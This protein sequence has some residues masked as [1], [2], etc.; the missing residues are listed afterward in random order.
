MQRWRDWRSKADV[1]NARLLGHAKKKYPVVDPMPG[2]WIDE[3]N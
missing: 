1:A 2:T 3:E